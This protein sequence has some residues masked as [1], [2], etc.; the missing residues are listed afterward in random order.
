[1]LRGAFATHLINHGAD[2]RVV[3]WLSATP[4]SRRRRSTR[5]SRASIEAAARATSS[6]RM[7]ALRSRTIA[8]SVPIAP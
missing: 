8:R 3:Q 4:T 2:L 6:A 5:M 7:I 1:V